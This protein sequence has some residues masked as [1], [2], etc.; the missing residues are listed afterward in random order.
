M[1]ID[2]STKILNLREYSISFNNL[3][4]EHYIERT[5][6]ILEIEALA[7]NDNNLIVI[8][9]TDG[10]GKTGLLLQLAK[11]HSFDSF[12]YFYNPS[13]KF[14]AKPDF[15]IQDIG[16]QLYFHLHSESIGDVAIN[17]VTF[18]TL[19][20]DLMRQPSKKNKPLFFILDG[21]DEIDDSEVELIK[22]L[23]EALPWATNNY[24]FIVSGSIE[25]LSKIFSQNI[26]KRPKTFR[27][28]RFTYEEMLSLFEWADSDTAKEVY[29]TW[30]GN[31]ESLSQIKRL[32]GSGLDIDDF[33]VNDYIAK[34]D[35]LERE[36]KMSRI[37][38]TNFEA[39]LTKLLCI[40]VFDENVRS[41]HKIC[42][43]LKVDLKDLLSNIKNITFLTIRADE[44]Q[45]ASTSIKRYILKKLQKFEKRTI[46]LLITYYEQQ[47][48]VTVINNVP[49]LLARIQ[50][51]A[52]IINLLTATRLGVIISSSQSF[53]DIK[54]QINYGYKASRSLSKSH[55]NVFK[56]AL[57]RSILLGLQKGD[58]NDY[59]L[60]ANISLKRHD[61][62]F[63][64]ISKTFLKEEKLK[65]L[66]K[67]AKEC[68]IQEI[69]V[70]ATVIEE[71]K[72]LLKEIDQEFLK[73]NIV[74]ISIG[75]AHFLPDLAMDILDRN[76]GGD[77]NE[78]S[79]ETILHHIAFIISDDSDHVGQDRSGLPTTNLE[80]N[81]FHNN[82][83]DSL[84]E[85][86]LSTSEYNIIDRVKT[87][88]NIFNKLYLLK[89]WI[90]KNPKSEH[91]QSIMEFGI[92]LIL[93]GSSQI[94][95]TTT[96]LLSIIHPITGIVSKQDA[97]HWVN[98][99]D[100]LLATISS[101]VNDKIKIRTW[102]IQTLFRHDATAA[103]QRM[104]ELYEE[105][106]QIQ[107]LATRCECF[108]NCWLL[109]NKLKENYNSEYKTFILEE[110]EIRK[111]IT[112]TV[113]ALLQN[114]ADHYQELIQ[115][116]EILPKIDLNFSLDIAKLLNT[117]PRRQDALV[118][119]LSSHTE[120]K[121]EKW[122]VST[123]L[124]TARLLKNK[125]YDKA[126][127]G[128]FNEAHRQKSD[129][130][131]FKSEFIKLLPLIGG[132][133]LPENRTRL[134]VKSIE[135]L[136]SEGS[137][138]YLLKVNYTKLL[139]KLKT[140]VNEFWRDI[141]NP[142]DRIKSG[143]SIS[144]SLATIDPSFAETYYRETENTANEYAINNET[145]MRLYYDS[146]RL[147]IRIY[148]KI[149][150]KGKDIT[151]DK[152]TRL[153]ERV[154]SRLDQAALWSELAARVGLAGNKKI[155]DT[156]VSNRLIPSLEGFRPKY[157]SPDFFDYLRL[158]AT[159]I[160]M[161]Q[162][163]SLKLYLRHLPA[164]EKETIIS[165]V[166]YSISAQVHETEPY[167]DQRGS[168]NLKYQEAI[169]IIGLMEEVESDYLIH[170]LI[171]KITN[172][173]KHYPN[174]FSKEQKG[175]LTQKLT[176]LV[177]RKL[178][179]KSSGVKHDGYLLA[180]KACISHFSL[181]SPYDRLSD[182]E[183]LSQ[184]A[185][186][187]PNVTDRALVQILLA[188]ECLVKSTKETLLVKGLTETDNIKSIREKI[189]LYEDALDELSALSPDKFKYFVLKLQSEILLLDE[190]ERYDNY[191]K[192]VDVTYRND[193][194]LAK[195]LVSALD[196]DRLRRS[197][198]AP[199]ADHFEMLETEKKVL[200]DYSKIGLVKSRQHIAKIAR[201]MLG[202]LNGRTR[203]AKNIDQTAPLLFASSKL[204]FAYSM[205]ILEFFVENIAGANVPAY[206]GLL[207]NLFES[208]NASAVLCFNFICNM[209][210][211]NQNALFSDVTNSESTLIVRP[212]MR[213][214]AFAFIEKNIKQLKGNE[215]FIIDPYFNENDISIL[216][217]L[218]NWSE[219]SKV[220][221]LT[222]TESEGEFSPF[223]L[224]N[225]WKK[226]SSEEH[227]TISVI[228]TSN[229]EK[230][231]PFHDRY[232]LVSDRN[233]GIKMGSSLN[234]VGVKKISDLT[235]I[236]ESDVDLVRDE[237]ITPFMVDRIKYW[238]N[239]TIKYQILEI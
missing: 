201:R 69:G 72:E 226:V 188:S 82:F 141:E 12:T 104:I 224:S 62:A 8:E 103:N 155:L 74:E 19:L 39:T 33:L 185:L 135:I 145:H 164:S 138:G 122:D 24:Y 230:K 156:L 18:N 130:A 56:F 4:D 9:G 171:R 21:L 97:I 116:L 101:P 16:Q 50:E 14:T 187:I 77:K 93:E 181:K 25:K 84:S 91:I 160:H 124:S 197:F 7:T 200:D 204:P 158:S 231:S 172:V 76:Y 161:S 2:P 112:D 165:A 143:Y 157:T 162:P 46:S 133:R 225:A 40:L 48:D 192:L 27:A 85:G 83:S 111:H 13:C 196:T 189:S 95:P 1:T 205:P 182:F 29:N 11:K 28:I 108:S 129:T 209:T 30:N 153:I 10:I 52:S 71:I 61:D 151:Y 89:T 222:S 194:E 215:L 73:E 90:N 66:I 235:T 5:N 186:S 58:I 60:K 53:A 120:N 115:T 31:P 3:Y 63:Y 6:L 128:I 167:R 193:K 117:L 55:E 80:I 229:Q 152:L 217:D 17:E 174:N 47:G 87:V 125:H 105:I 127:K 68:K 219:A 37:D 163:D 139:H 45:F 202:E 170:W 54:R 223:S 232:I 216:R 228:I 98:R 113:S 136:E 23:I 148:S 147:A 210:N 150:S 212:G 175:D 198:Q 81:S 211:R 173:A 43:M 134:L 51:W 214:E 234:S 176:D 168:V 100:H 119:C 137:N 42:E 213:N 180:C 88:E 221:V 236:G 220:F 184:L 65:M 195:T 227:P 34:D 183:S 238:E 64:L 203:F 114:T 107:D 78:S 49:G 190:E 59:Q 92:G 206:D 146:V 179:N 218:I 191:R 26:L 75:L 121:F 154:P 199:L 86:I 123:L 118:S 41:I 94:K 102:Q 32:L 178:P 207:I 132:I 67:Y 38:I 144:S 57:Y 166:C 140:F 208:A 44:V 159:A 70:E 35:L 96:R 15:L 99:I 126:I 169:Q 79:P 22:P 110:V 233:A 36:W 177:Q 239:Q 237:I 106:C 142:I 131:N 20:L 149:I 109:L